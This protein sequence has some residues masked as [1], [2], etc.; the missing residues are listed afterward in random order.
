MKTTSDTHHLPPIG[1]S[2]NIRTIVGNTVSILASDVTNRIATFILYALIA[3]Y[4]GTYE[5]GQIALGLTLFRSFQLLA[6]AGLQALITREVAKYPAKTGQYLVNS[7]AVVISTSLLSVIALMLFTY[8]MD[9]A[10]STT[11]II[12]LLS[13]GLFPYS[14]SV[15]CDAVF[16]AREKMQY[17]AYSNLLVNV[18]KIALAFLLLIRGYGLY[19]LVI[20]LIFSHV[21]ALGSKWWL[22]LR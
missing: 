20:L 21:A 15:I 19:Q 13:L 22:L 5:F 7:S 10:P 14:L 6:V 12:R 18:I 17:I 9:Y 16:R 4:L 8:S 1:A 11:S 2:I 3:R